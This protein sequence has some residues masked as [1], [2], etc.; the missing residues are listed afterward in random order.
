MGQQAGM[1]DQF[2]KRLIKGL[3]SHYYHVVKSRI[4]DY[5]E[6]KNEVC[7]EQ[8]SETSEREFVLQSP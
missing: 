3:P 6:I 5:F 7:S 4:R 2:T 1:D 8:S